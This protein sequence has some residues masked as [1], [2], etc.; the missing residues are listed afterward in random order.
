MKGDMDIVCHAFDVKVARN[1]AKE[2]YEP[3]I[4]GAPPDA[5]RGVATPKKDSP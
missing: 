1:E 4:P 2:S 3:R 5:G